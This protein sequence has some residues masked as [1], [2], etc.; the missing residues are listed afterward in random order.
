[1]LHGSV[2]AYLSYQLLNDILNGDDAQRVLRRGRG[3]VK[4]AVIA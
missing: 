4:D 3:R 2:S 1:M